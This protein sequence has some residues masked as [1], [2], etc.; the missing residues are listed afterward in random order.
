MLGTTLTNRVISQAKP[1][2]SIYIIISTITALSMLILGSVILYRINAYVVQKT[3]ASILA[4]L[5]SEGIFTFNKRVFFSVLQIISY[6]TFLTFILSAIFHKPFSWLQIIAFFTGAILLSLASIAGAAVA[7]K[8]ATK[9]LER[10]R[11]YIKHG[12]MTLFNASFAISFII[13]GTVVTGLLFV[14]ATLGPQS[15]IGYGLGV[16]ITAFFLRIGGGLFKTSTDIGSDIITELDEDM[17]SSESNNPA[18]VLDM[19]GNYIGDIIGFSS[20]M[21]GSYIMVILS[22]LFFT[23][24]ISTLHSG[25][26]PQSMDHNLPFILITISLLS[27]FIGFGVSALRI[28]TGAYKNCLLEGLYASLV[29]NGI[30]TYWA[31]SQFSIRLGENPNLFPAFLTGLVAA[32]L[33]GTTSEYLTSSRFKPTKNSL[34]E[35][36]NGPSITILNGLSV[37]LKS[38]GLFAIFIIITGLIAYYFSGIYGIAIASLG[39]LSTAP[40][41]IG[42]TIFNPLSANNLKIL[43]LTLNQSITDQHTEKIEELGQTTVAV[44]NGFASAAA[45]LATISLLTSVFAFNFDNLVISPIIIIGVTFGLAIPHTV[46]GYLLRTLVRIVNA[47]INETLRQFKDIPYLLE[48]KA[49]PDIIRATDNQARLSIDGLVIP[50]II[51][52]GIPIIT[53]YIFGIDIL[54]GLILGVILTTSTQSFGI[55]NTGDAL[56]NIKNYIKKGHFGGQNSK[57]FKHAQIADN[58]G[59][60]YKD[61]LGPAMNIM[62]KSIC[63]ITILLVFILNP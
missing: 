38:N 29:L 55:S 23:G 32:I 18:K 25:N 6:V 61:L 45:I 16:S 21:I 53:A 36:E 5:L 14:I 20:D 56:H 48:N 8:I 10:S 41:I 3:Q 39:M 35:V 43:R 31:L 12:L 58:V 50:G 28:N 49:K 62:I 2:M 57:T 44:R 34:K 26:T 46:N 1:H 9:T 33:F 27:S 17:E 30:G 24:T 52:V 51:I 63:I 15:A 13:M 59:D 54:L 47:T 22:C 40:T 60:A 11:F 42:I 7:P 4:K 19:V 37:G